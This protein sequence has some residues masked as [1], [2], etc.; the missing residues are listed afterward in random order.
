[1]DKLLELFRFKKIRGKLFILT[2]LITFIPM[3]LISLAVYRISADRLMQNAEAHTFAAGGIA[4]HY[5]NR[6]L[7]DFSELFNVIISSSQ[8]QCTLTGVSNQVCQNV[9]GMNEPSDYS[10]IR[11]SYRINNA[12]NTITQSKS[13]V[14]RYVIYHMTA[15]PQWRLYGNYITPTEAQGWYDRLGQSNMPIIRDSKS[16]DQNMRDNKETMLVGRLLKRTSGDFASLGFIILEIDKTKFFEGLSFLNANQ[17]ARLMIA[18][19]DG[20]LI[21]ALPDGEGEERINTSLFAAT[22]NIHPQAGQFVRIDGKW[23]GSVQQTLPYGW[24]LVHIIDAGS[25]SKDVRA[26]RTITVWVFVITL[27]MGLVLANWISGTIRKPLNRLSLLI[28][29]SG[30]IDKP[31]AIKFDPDDEV[32]QIGHRFLRMIEENKALH[33]QVYGALMKR[34]EAEIHAL[35]AQINPHFLYNTLESL[36]WLAFTRNQFDISDVV[37]KLGKYF[38]LTINKG[39]QIISLPEE[40][41]HVLAYF[42]V[43]SFRYPDRFDFFQSFEEDLSHYYVPKFILQPIVENAIYH[44]L[45]QKEGQGSIVIGGEVRDGVLT[46]QITDDGNGITPE[47]IEEIT[48]ALNADETTVTYGLKNVHDRLRLRF[49]DGFGVRIQSEPGLYTTIMLAMPA[50]TEAE[51]A[52]DESRNEGLNR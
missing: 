41:D 29:V 45:K 33:K 30:S 2:T 12:M 50:I 14:V 18:D 9:E 52:G 48:R 37:G 36:K 51:E 22:K 31:V 49:G 19:K 21:Y 27:V 7:V 17:Q 10:Y 46:F 5:L 8:I 1:M 35:Q 39:N 34:K 4:N 44:G 20:Q 26:I 28:K 43:Q 40:L 3:L 47:R 42:Q 11:S 38:R 23:M 15:P 32:G 16:L 24:S 25:L 13:Y 6:I